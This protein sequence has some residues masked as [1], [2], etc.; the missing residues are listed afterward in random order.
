MAEMVDRAGVQLF[1]ARIIALTFGKMLNNLWHIAKSRLYIMTKEA[2]FTPKPGL[3]KTASARALSK[4]G[5]ILNITINSYADLARHAR[6]GLP[7]SS[8]ETF[9]QQGFSRKEVDWI[10]PART[11]THRKAGEGRLTM[12]ESDKLIRAASIQSLAYE[13]LGSEEKA[14]AWLHKERKLFDGLSAMEAMKTEHGAQQVQ[15]ALIQLSTSASLAYQQ[16]C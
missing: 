11:F 4:M 6:A 3:A 12:D 16:L 15:E 9:T 5:S 7:V 1:E 13:V 10:I 14:L 8:F 2:V